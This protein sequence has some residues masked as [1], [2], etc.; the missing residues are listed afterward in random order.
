MYYKTKPGLLKN[1]LTWKPEVLNAGGLW[2]LCIVDTNSGLLG[3]LYI[4]CL[5]LGGAARA[6]SAE[7]RGVWRYGQ[8]H[9][10]AHFTSGWAAGRLVYRFIEVTP[11]TLLCQ[12]IFL[13]IVNVCLVRIVLGDDTFGQDVVKTRKWIECFCYL[14]WGIET[15]LRNWRSSIPATFISRCQYLIPLFLAHWSWR[16]C[17]GWLG[18][19]HQLSK[20]LSGQGQRNTVL[21]C[22]MFLSSSQLIMQKFSRLQKKIRYLF[23]F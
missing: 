15:P 18:E 10:T 5:W 22:Y 21:V 13:S 1:C 16:G 20:I 17:I 12:W 2:I 11:Q 9:W 4:C 8:A 23:G 19:K 3:C 7:D 6:S 14:E